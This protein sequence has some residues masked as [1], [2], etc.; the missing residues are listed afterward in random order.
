[1]RHWAGGGTDTDTYYMFRNLFISNCVIYSSQY[2]GPLKSVSVSPVDSNSPRLRI[3][4]NPDPL[5]LRKAVHYSSGIA[6]VNASMRVGF[7]FPLL[8]SA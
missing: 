1:M 3:T 6:K 2:F 7:I 5:L 8:K 4:Q